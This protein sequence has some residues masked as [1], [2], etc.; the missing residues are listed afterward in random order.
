MK[1]KDAWNVFRGCSRAFFGCSYYHIYHVF[2]G[3]ANVGVFFVALLLE[4]ILGGNYV[5]SSFFEN[6]QLIYKFQ[7]M[8]N[9]FESLLKQPFS[10]IL[11]SRGNTD[12]LP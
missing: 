1:K 8:Q 10:T 9:H 3:F 5:A 2:I 4:A 11:W 6:E 12:L 7:M